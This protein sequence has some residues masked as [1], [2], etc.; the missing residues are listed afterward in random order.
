MSLKKGQNVTVHYVGTLDD[1][2][3]FDSSRTRGE[4]L[5]F[6]LGSEKIMPAFQDAILSMQIGE[7]KSVQIASENAYGPV[8]PEGFRVVPVD[9]FDSPEELIVGA[10]VQGQSDNGNRFAAKIEEI[11]TDGVKLN[12][13][14]PMAGKNLNFE[15]EVLK[16]V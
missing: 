15:I 11:S 8:N 9:R 7:T 6:E 16:A 2:T 14:H 3:E 1:G 13:N 10:I 5:K 12:F 4:P